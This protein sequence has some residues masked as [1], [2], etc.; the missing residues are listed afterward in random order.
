MD[1]HK[2]LAV[3]FSSNAKWDTQIDFIINLCAKMIGI[4]RKLKMKISR[5]WLN[6]MFLSFVKPILEY[7][8]LVWDSCSNDNA[9]RK[10][11]IQLEAA[12]IITGLTRSTHLDSLYNEIG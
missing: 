4:L 2:H 6:Q 8:D 11:K 10:A 3:Y 7:A 5:R 12:R 9:N 1:P